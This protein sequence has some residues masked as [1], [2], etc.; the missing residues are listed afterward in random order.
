VKC[1]WQRRHCYI[2]VFWDY[3]SV[4]HLFVTKVLELLFSNFPFMFLYL[5]MYMALVSTQPLTEMSKVKKVKESH[6]R[7]GVTQRV[8]GGLGSQI[9]MTFGT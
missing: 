4:L 7:P 6:N 8:P 1:V 2:C 5:L 3:I 9:S